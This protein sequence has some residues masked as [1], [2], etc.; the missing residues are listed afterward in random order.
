M[1]G[2][3]GHGKQENYLIDLKDVIPVTSSL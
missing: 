1:Q 2:K 3:L